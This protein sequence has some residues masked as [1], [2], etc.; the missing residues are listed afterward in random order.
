MAYTIRRTEEMLSEAGINFNWAG[1]VWVQGNADDDTSDPVL[2]KTFGEDTARVW[3]G[4][5]E[6]LGGPVPVV[7]TGAGPKNQLS[8]GKE[9]ATQVVEGCQ[10]T[11]IDS[12]RGAIDDSLATCIPGPTDPCVESPGMYR[13]QE[14][15]EYYGW[16]PRVP[17]EMKP[18]GSTDKTFA[19][20]VDYPNDLHSAYEGHI[21]KGQMLA[22]AYIR[23]FTDESLGELGDDI[24]TLFPK[25]RCEDGESP[26]E[27]NLCWTDYQ[28]DALKEE[29]CSAAS[30]PPTVPTA[31]TVAP[32]PTPVPTAAPTGPT[33]PTLAPTRRPKKCRDI[34]SNR[35]DLPK[36]GRVKERKNVHCR[37]FRDVYKNKRI[38]KKYC[39]R[40][41]KINS[42]PK[43]GRM[44]K[45]NLVCKAACLEINA[46][47]KHCQED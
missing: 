32:E 15:F 34:A 31:P 6:Q 7:D 45:L 5:R 8:S 3:E 9:Y 25:T 12:N 18:P 19:W 2:W 20:F 11:T 21:L 47:S 1:I 30:P 42:G 41:V 33:V 4:F 28:D 40:K 35:F 39:I 23:E 10:A 38:K 16:D 36:I 13:N 29:T 17:D 22:N 43:K 46:G 14:I 24:A 27:E 37:W 26:S 44:V